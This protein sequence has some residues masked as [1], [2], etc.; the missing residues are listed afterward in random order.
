MSRY[1]WRSVLARSIPCPRLSRT[2]AGGGV[3]TVFTLP[4]LTLTHSIQ[5]FHWPVYT[6]SLYF[7]PFNFFISLIEALYTL[8]N[9]VPTFQDPVCLFSILVQLIQLDSW[10]IV[11]LTLSFSHC[12]LG[13][14]NRLSF[15]FLT[16][17]WRILS[18]A[19]IPGPG[20]NWNGLILD[21]IKAHHLFVR[22]W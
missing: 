9:C 17:Y 20:N 6:R 5:H 12:M 22:L 21:R 14:D 8:S 16:N 15:L 4:G 19:T 7:S 11:V 3:L 2:E 13:W 18:I 1:W 10:W